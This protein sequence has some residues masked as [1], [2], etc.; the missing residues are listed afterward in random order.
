M[1]N[2][3]KSLVAPVLV[4]FLAAGVANGAFYQWSRTATTNATADA[5]INW[6]EGMPPSAVNDSARAMMA[7]LAEWR[8][9]NSGVLVPTYDANPASLFTV[10]TYEG[11]PSTPADGTTLVLAF[12]ASN[13]SGVSLKADG[14]SSFLIQNTLASG[15]GIGSAQ[16]IP[17]AQYRLRFASAYSAWIIQGFADPIITG[18]CRLDYVDATHVQLSR[19]N[20]SKLRINGKTEDIPSSAVTIT[21]SGLAASTTYY[22]YA[23][24]DTT[25]KLQFG[26]SSYLIAPDGT[27]VH[28]T[29]PNLALVGMVHTNASGQF[30]SDGNNRLVASF[31]NRR[32]T[33]LVGRTVEFGIDSTT[34]IEGDV[35]ARISF[36]AWS[37][38]AVSVAL[39]GFSQNNTATATN[40]TFI[41]RDGAS[42]EATASVATAAA[43]GS[44]MPVSSATSIAVPEGYHFEAVNA[45]VTAGHGIFDAG[46]T[47]V[48]MQ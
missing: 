23:Y 26:A 15:V 11:L 14:G 44:W 16:I 34:A 45:L 25:M 3:L 17:G 1:R 22:V 35:T 39:S 21:N 8:D 32:P 18:Q 40:E 19:Y 48:V 9:D 20:G 12:P 30:E 7:R 5:T 41:Y 2:F 13:V 42:Q 4:A 33:Y 47:G 36:V 28:A 24:M 29:A 31:Y 46:I 38:D 10:S 43:A 6:A 27:A 37:N